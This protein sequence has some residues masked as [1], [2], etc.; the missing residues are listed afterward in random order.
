MAVFLSWPQC[1]NELKHRDGDCL[2]EEK[3]NVLHHFNNIYYFKTYISQENL[4][5]KIFLLKGNID[6]FS[7]LI[8][9]L[10]MGMVN[11]SLLKMRLS[12][13]MILTYFS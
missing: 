9:S 6:V 3:K 1:V 4:D 12:T 5:S 13:A 7:H 8:S 11:P 10:H 2:G